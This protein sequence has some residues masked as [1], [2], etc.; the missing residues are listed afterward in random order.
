MAVEGADSGFL[1]S[2]R[3]VLKAVAAGA[4]GVAGSGLAAGRAS[5][6]APAEL[7]VRTL[8]PADLTFSQAAK[9]VP[10]A[11][12]SPNLR[13]LDDDF[14]RGLK[15]YRTLR[16]EPDK[17]AP[18]V[19]AGGGTLEFDGASPYSV[20]LRSDTAQQAAS[21]GVIAD[22]E[23]LAGAAGQ[24]G[25]GAEDT[26][27][28]GLAQDAG[29]YAVGWYNHATGSAGIDVA[30]GGAVTT[31]AAADASLTAPFR[32]AFTLT[33]P[34]ADVLADDGSGWRVLTGADISGTLD[35]R[36]I[37]PSISNTAFDTPVKLTDGNTLGQTFTVDRPFVAAG[38]MFP[39]YQTTDASV[40]LSLYQD[41][42]GGTLITS[43]RLTDVPDDSWQFLTF[44]TPLPAGTYYLEQSQPAGQIAWWSNSTGVID[45]GGA[46]ENGAAVD[47]DRTVRVMFPAPRTG[48]DLLASYRNAVGARADGG[49]IT[50]GRLEAGYFGQAGV[51][52]PDIVSEADGTPYIRDGRL[53][54]T[55]TNSGLAGGIPSAHMGVF[56]MSLTD[57]R[58]EE[59]GKVYFA[60]GDMVLGDH[61]G[62]IVHDPSVGGFRLV[63]VTFGDYDIFNTSTTQYAAARA[64]LLHGVHVL[65]PRAVVRGIDPYPVRI[66]GTWW[67]A[68]SDSGRTT[69]YRFTDDAFREPVLVAANDNGGVY[70]EGTKVSRI[71]EEWYI[72]SSS[73]TDYRVYDLRANLVGT[74]DAPHP[75]GYIPH[76]MVLPV[77]VRGDRTRFLHLSMDGDGDAVSGAFGHFLVNVSDQIVRGREFPIR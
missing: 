67:M 4:V 70:Y 12:V 3:G 20:L 32:L 5:A 25:D 29:N 44:D 54:L 23:R 24:G 9:S 28:V 6:A 40:T 30:V 73:G 48:A 13:T 36:G 47:G 55:V 10:Y 58:L 2:R 35:L 8:R 31:F 1:S 19:R 69:S 17:A 59:V 57:F 68:L 11:V 46:Y 60:R 7:D 62:R 64:D 22:V 27:L 53:Y 26:V 77:P 33:G 75:D 42:P 63:A 15:H 56:R 72:L 65:T 38:G 39:T 14:R 41:G 37:G 52:D 43:S 34:G 50:L 51:R 18:R 16:P 66:D 21:T 61:A 49:T 45:W 71:G 76:P 74:L